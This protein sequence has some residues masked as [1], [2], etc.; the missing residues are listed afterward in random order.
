MPALALL[1]DMR[2]T[3][4]Q[5]RAHPLGNRGEGAG[6]AL[7]QEQRQEIH[8]EENVTQFV[9]ELRVVALRGRVRQ[10]VR[11]LDRVRDDRA[12][13]LLAVP[14]AFDPQATGD[15]V[16][17]GKRGGGV[18]A[19][20]QPP[21]GVAGGAPWVGGAVP[22]GAVPGGAVPGG[23]VPGGAPGRPSCSAPGGS[24]SASWG[25]GCG[26]WGSGVEAPPGVAS[27]GFS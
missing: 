5:L 17:P 13:V 21:G 19:H 3:P 15:L 7:L 11:L 12:L 2:V 8:L 24:S 16:E 14:G 20:A 23:G 25:G 26:P 10:L 27:S 6:A 1:E 18:A 9:L 4:D 22:G